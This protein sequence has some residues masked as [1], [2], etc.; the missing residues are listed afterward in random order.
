[1]ED[2]FKLKTLYTES[3]HPVGETPCQSE[4][5]ELD[6]VIPQPNSERGLAEQGFPA[7]PKAAM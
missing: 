1:M 6:R 2:T 7:A 4:V 3:G 5:E